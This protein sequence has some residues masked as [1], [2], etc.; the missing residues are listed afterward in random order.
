VLGA[1]AWASNIRQRA[2]Q[3]GTR[4]TVRTAS[5]HLLSAAS[6][7]AIYWVVTPYAAMPVDGDLMDAGV[8][9]YLDTQHHL[10]AV[11][12]AGASAF[13]AGMSALACLAL[14]QRYAAARRERPSVV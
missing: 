14:M 11:W 12:A 10:M 6:F 8:P 4:R 5:L 3:Q 2:A 9:G 13:L 1:L 7:V